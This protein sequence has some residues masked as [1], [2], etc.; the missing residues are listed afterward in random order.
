M[1]LDTY[2]GLKA[3]V[4]AWLHRT[5]LTSVIPDFITL[6]EAGFA[7]GMPSIGVDPLR[8]ERMVTI[9]TLTVDAEF[10]AVPADFDG[11][12][13]M[14]LTDDQGHVVPIENITPDSMD[15]MRASRDSHSGQPQAYCVYN[16]QLRFSPVP[17]KAYTTT[18]TYWTA[19]PALSDSNPSNWVLANYPN[20]YLWGTLLQAAPYLVDDGRIAVWQSRYQEALAGL[21]IAERLNRGSRNTPG[22]RADDIRNVRRRYFNINLGV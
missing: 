13:N 21:A 1:A 16:R 20:V 4:A 7:T 11:P 5:D 19:I 3:S 8:S 18:L 6:A 17:D 2:T 10:E 15:T 12:M 14:T 9:T 22:F